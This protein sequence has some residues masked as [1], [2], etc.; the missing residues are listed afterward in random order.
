MGDDFRA[1]RLDLYG[2]NEKRTLADFRRSGSME[3][4]AGQAQP[5]ALAH[6]MGNSLERCHELFRTCCPVNVV[7]LQEVA[8][9]RE[10][11]AK[12]LAEA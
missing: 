8:E 5:A 12:R 3:A 1:V 6:V 4:F 11:R 7:S 9:A 10:R 2:P